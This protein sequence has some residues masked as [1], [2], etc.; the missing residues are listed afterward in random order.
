MQ[1]IH[2]QKKANKFLEGGVFYP[3]GHI[4]AGF[5]SSEAAKGAA[6]A[7]QK[8]LVNGGIGQDHLTYFS[9]STMAREAS[10]N[11][12]HA[13][14]LSV[15]ASLPAREMQLELAKEGCDFLMIYAPDDRDQ[16]EI[17]RLLQ[18]HPLRYLIKYH[19][20]VIEDL[21]TQMDSSADKQE[22]ARVP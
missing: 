5:E 9:A 12:E 10:D 17:I 2:D 11:L 15:G 13:G 16:K 21:L 1:A 7:A 20:L 19:R 18:E 4:L 22:R 14:I 3:T 8:A 6:Q